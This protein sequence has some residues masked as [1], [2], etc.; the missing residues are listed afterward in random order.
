MV[1]QVNNNPKGYYGWVI[2]FASLVAMAV[3][4]GTLH[5]FGVFFKPL[6]QEFGWTRA[7]TSGVFSLGG[8][9]QGVVAVLVGLISN[10]VGP[11]K[12]VVV[13]G[14]L[15]GLSYVMGSW[16]TALWQ[17]YLY[18]GLLQGGAR[19][20]P[21]NPLMATIARWFTQRRGLAIGIALSGGGVGTI[22]FPI[23]GNS[24][25]ERFEWQTAFVIFGIIAGAMMIGAGLVVRARPPEIPRSAQGVESSRSDATVNAGNQ[26]EEQTPVS[27]VL[28]SRSFWLVI[29]MGF[30]TNLTVSMVFVHLVPYA[31]DQKIPAA[32]AASF[33]S[34]IGVFNIVGKIGMGGFSD[35]YGLRWGMLIC[36]GIGS[37]S[38]FWLNYASALWMFYSFAVVF[39][40]AYSGWMPL[41]PVLVMRIFGVGSMSAVLGFL[42][43]ANMI[44]SSVG[45]YV[46]GYLFD[47][48]NSYQWAFFLAGMV[49]IV[50]IPC[51]LFV[52]SPASPLVSHADDKK[53][54]VGSKKLENGRQR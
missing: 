21:Y 8:I 36:F 18:F 16:T 28:S 46:A 4:V 43:A 40:L 14:V 10:R 47:V 29:V 7:T 32:V 53:Q 34:V 24:L 3:T 31:T 19:G 9:I 12:L 1:K 23:L 33:V 45:A 48:T 11:R 22:I 41:F 51:Q 39:G 54:E 30:F 17:L 49:L 13:S 15:L 38:L 50:S 20:V 26:Q 5:A 35:R 52:K 25:I 2:V 27:K 42:T 44:G 6:L 37:L